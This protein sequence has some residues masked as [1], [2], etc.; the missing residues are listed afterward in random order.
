MPNFTASN[1]DIDTLSPHCGGISFLYLDNY[2]QWP[3][4]ANALQVFQLSA[5]V[6]SA[7]KQMTQPLIPK[8]RLLYFP[9]IFL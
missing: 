2:F 3:L 5:V 6:E 8:R 9:R 1:Y 7:T 4:N